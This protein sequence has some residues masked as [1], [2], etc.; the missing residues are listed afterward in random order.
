MSQIYYFLR[1]Q[2]QKFYLYA[3]L[4][5]NLILLLLFA[6]F[7]QDRSAL[8]YKFLLIAAI[9]NLSGTVVWGAFFTNRNF[10]ARAAIIHILIDTFLIFFL[11]YPAVYQMPF[12]LILPAVLIVSIVFLLT[13]ESSRNILIVVF[14][15]FTIASGIY[16]YQGLIQKPELVYSANLLIMG[17]FVFISYISL[18]AIRDLEKH[19]LSLKG[20]REELKKRYR[21]LEQE[22][23][24]NKE[25][26]DHLNRNVRKKDIEIKNIL[27]LSGQLNFRSDSKKVLTSFLLTVIGQIGSSYAAILTRQSRDHNYIQV[28]IQKGLRG[29]DLSNLRIYFHSN[30]IQI[31]NSV[32]EPIHVNQ[33]PTDGLYTDEVHLLE[34]F[35]KDLICPI[36][37]KGNL[38]GVF[39]V[40]H[41][42]AGKSFNEADMNLIA[43]VANQVSFVLEQT[44]ITH[45]YQDFYS[46][47]IRAMLHSLE[48]KYAYAK[49][50]KIRTANYVHHLARKMGLNEQEIKDMTY[51]ALLHDIGKI[52]VKD[53]YLLNSTK[54]SGLDTGLKEKI[55]QH[56]VEGSKILSSAG[57]N[58]TIV[59]MALHHHEFYNGKGFPHKIG[60]N[61]LTVGSRILSVCNA[62]DA[63]VSDRP[64]RKALHPATAKEY[65]HYYAGSQ[66]DPAMVKLFLEELASNQ[67]MHRYKN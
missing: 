27:N 29:Q 37:L 4:A 52:A 43:I 28:Y 64:H 55:L 44:Q 21:Q 47:T 41:K 50:H 45:D 51:G 7:L 22:Y 23:A 32:R 16:S 3:K 34:L 48:A 53:E 26:I 46:K 11:V 8:E 19:Y 13:A 17:V 35:R 63:M 1:Y 5:G 57:F 12:F 58:E 31:L 10:D 56:A 49:G 24:A 6:G 38:A 20:D 66:F 65:L 61:D 18:N 67:E 36:F 60:E 62:F 54:F 40:G 2:K 42:I 15:L 14:I 25:Q 9:V 59:D 39:V 33:I 30:L